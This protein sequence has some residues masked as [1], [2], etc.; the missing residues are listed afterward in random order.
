MMVDMKELIRPRPAGTNGRGKVRPM[1]I[2]EARGIWKRF[3]DREVVQDVS[4]SVEAGEVLGV[5]GPNGAGKTT[6]MRMLLDIIQ[7]DQGDVLLFGEPFNHLHRSMLGY[8]PEERG[9]YRDLRVGETLEY[10]GALKGMPRSE[11]RGRSAEILDRLGMT[12]YRDKK[13]KELSKGMSQLIQLAA[14][15]L[16]RPRLLVLDEP[17]AGL[18]P[19]NLR[20]V[21]ELLVEQQKEGVAIMLSTHLMNE[22]EELC[23]RVLMINAGRVVLYGDLAEVRES[24]G[25]KSIIVE[26][27]S[28]PDGLPGVDKVNE[29]GHYR[30]LVMSEGTESATVFQALAAAGVDVK[31]FEVAGLPLE[32]IFIQVVEGTH[33]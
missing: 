22:V 18:D 13:V 20:L 4:F 14:T 27:T 31:R 15:F 23:S 1:A 10:L 9:L 19:V 30:E 32:D 29:H 24:F 6:T 7:P 26:S 28:L 17:F 12:E 8:L 5:V 11:A 33:R 16:H 25:G 21:K 2:A 3:G